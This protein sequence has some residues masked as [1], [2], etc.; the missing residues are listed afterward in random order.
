MKKAAVISRATIFSLFLASFLFAD[1]PGYKSRPWTIRD[2]ESYPARLSSE[3]ITIAVEPL[4]RDAMAEQ[5]FDADDMVTRGIMPLAIVIFNDNDFPVEV[6]GLSIELL[7]GNNRI[8]SISPNDAA[9]L[10]LKKDKSFFPQPVLRFPKGEQNINALADFEGKFL[11]HKIVGPHA[12]GGGFLYINTRNS[13]D[14]ISLLAQSVVYIPNIYRLDNRSR[15][16][17][18]EIELRIDITNG[19]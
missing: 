13:V 1:V 16:M 2:R 11:G 15:M 19:K 10:A 9:Y 8:K 18:F 12:K 5:V 14:I 7:N 6:D 17:Y 4:Y 3:G